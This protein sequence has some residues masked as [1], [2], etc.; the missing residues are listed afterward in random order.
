MSLHCNWFNYLQLLNRPLIINVVHIMLPFS[1]VTQSSCS[2]LVNESIE[3]HHRLHFNGHSISHSM[4]T[5]FCSK[6]PFNIY[7]VVGCHGG[8][9]E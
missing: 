5:P 3:V 4:I 7:L 2:S 1:G 8:D 6:G 9:F